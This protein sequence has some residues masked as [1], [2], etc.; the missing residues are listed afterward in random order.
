[1]RHARAVAHRRAE[2]YGEEVVGVA[3]IQMYKP[4]AALF[5]DELIRRRAKLGDL[6]YALGP[7]PA[8]IIAAFYVL[9]GDAAIFTFRHNY[10]PPVPPLMGITLPRVLFFTDIIK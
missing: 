9:R 5:V 6:L 4:R 3:V 10:F 7:K 2:R 8:Q 1:V